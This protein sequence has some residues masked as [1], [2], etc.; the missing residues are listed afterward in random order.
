MGVLFQ[1]R[2]AYWTVGRN[3]RFQLRTTQSPTG[4]SLLA[5]LLPETGNLQLATCNLQPSN[6][7]TEVRLHVLC[8][9]SKYWYRCLIIG[10]P[11]EHRQSHRCIVI[12]IILLHLIIITVI[13]IIIG[14][15]AFLVIAFF[16]RFSLIC[17]PVFTFL[18]FAKIGS[19]RGG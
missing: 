14:K 12:F 5:Y 9:N 16:R 8:S 13:I 18:D 15:T 19:Y 3:I 6:L 2:L 4:K 11:F 10:C 17:H 1:D 7:Q